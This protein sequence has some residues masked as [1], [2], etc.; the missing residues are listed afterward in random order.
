MV[1]SFC[2]YTVTNINDG[3]LRGIHMLKDA[4]ERNLVPERS[5]SILIML[6]DGDA[7][8][9]EGEGGLNPG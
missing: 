3:L 9:G 8:T 1:L 5:T 2:L 6:T 7:N 4:R